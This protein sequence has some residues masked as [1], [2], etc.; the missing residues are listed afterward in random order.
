MADSNLKTKFDF[1]IIVVW[2]RLTIKSVHFILYI[3]LHI[4]FIKL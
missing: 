2:C 4:T 3:K 1:V